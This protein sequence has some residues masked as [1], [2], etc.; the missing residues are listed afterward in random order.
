MPGNPFTLSKALAPTLPIVVDSPHSGTDYPADFGSVLTG[1]ALRQGEDTWVHELWGSAPAH[2]ATLLAADFP[3]AYIDPNRSLVDIDAEL[4]DAPWPGPV[5]PSRKTELGIG[6]VWR[7]MDGKPIYDRRLAVAEIQRRIDRCWRPYHA[8]LADALAAAGAQGPRWHLNVHSMPD[9]SYRRLGLPEQPLADFVL[10]NLDG[11]TCDE[12]TIAIIED[13]LQ[14]AGYSVARNEPF[15][16][17]EIIRSSGQPQRGWHSLQI[18]VKRSLYM[19]ESR[20]K[21]AG[22]DGVQRAADQALAA[23]A[24]H[25]RRSRG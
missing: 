22:F 20:K 18:E 19:D 10:G 6:L 25:A 15:K 17:V 7:L 3:R 11:S 14:S 8:A 21:N 16:G 23:L 2:G 4:L 5:E 24:A 12:A 9:D 13:A 1:L